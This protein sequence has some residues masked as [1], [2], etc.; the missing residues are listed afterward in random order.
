MTNIS[1]LPNDCYCHLWKTDPEVLRSEGVPEGYCG[2]CDS[3]IGGQVCG[4]P[5][6]VRQGAGPY[7]FCWCDEHQPGF[8][9]INFGCILF[10]ALLVVL[11]GGLLYW[12]FL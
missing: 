9:P 10:A 6:H 3:E 2:F 4:K 11:I 1:N 8:N 5:G 12:W 7:T